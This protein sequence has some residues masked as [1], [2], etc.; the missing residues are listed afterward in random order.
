MILF[1][2]SLWLYW[3]TLC[4]LVRSF[5]GFGPQSSESMA[6]GLVLR[7]EVTVEGHG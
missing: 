5:R 6:S 4:P 3:V 7:Q 2:G 1:P